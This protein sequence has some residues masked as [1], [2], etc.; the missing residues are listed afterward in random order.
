MT[1]N[2]YAE[3]WLWVHY[4]MQ[5]K[6]S[7]IIRNYLLARRDK[8]IVDPIPLAISTTIPQAEVKLAGHVAN[9]QPVDRPRL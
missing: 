8:Q 1:A 2:D 7:P 5:N 9:I 4:L 6:Q 3:A